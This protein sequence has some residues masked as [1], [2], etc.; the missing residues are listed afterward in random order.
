MRMCICVCVYMCVCVCIVCVCMCGC[1]HAYVHMYIYMCIHVYACA[2]I[3]IYMRMC[4]CMCA[5]I[6]ACVCVCTSASCEATA[7][8]RLDE[9]SSR[10]AAARR[11]VSTSRTAVAGLC[12]Q[13][14]RGA[15]F[16][17]LQRQRQGVRIR[18]DHRRRRYLGRRGRISRLSLAHDCR[19]LRAPNSAWTVVVQPFPDPE[20][21]PALALQRYVLIISPW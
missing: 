14:Q 3:Y 9:T 12:S 6:C 18:A 1:V 8:T 16:R 13:S 7:A 5:Y 20:A 19:W 4:V 2:H 17:P 15:G 11:F 10:V 21:R